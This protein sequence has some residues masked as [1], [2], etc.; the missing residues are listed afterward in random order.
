MSG[1][2]PRS[3]AIFAAVLRADARSRELAKAE[4][5]TLPDPA[6]AAISE[7]QKAARMIRELYEPFDPGR[8]G[9]AVARTMPRVRAAIAACRADDGR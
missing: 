5:E 9:E 4:A 8:F 6:V 3:A 2:D 7:L 1:T